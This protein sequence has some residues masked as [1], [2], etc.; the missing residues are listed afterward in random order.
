MRRLLQWENAPVQ[1]L[2]DAIWSEVKLIIDFTIKETY[3]HIHTMKMT[4]LADEPSQAEE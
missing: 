2:S 3:T 1:V 4:I